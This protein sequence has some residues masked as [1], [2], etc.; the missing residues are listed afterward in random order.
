MYLEYILTVMMENLGHGVGNSHADGQTKGKGVT[1]SSSSMNWKETTAVGP[2]KN[3]I[4]L[5]PK[6]LYHN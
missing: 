4:I 5:R 1:A 6:P 3:K 2:E